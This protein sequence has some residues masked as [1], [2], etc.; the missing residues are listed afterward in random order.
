MTDEKMR[1]ENQNKENSSEMNV[2]IERAYAR[3]HEV[4]W[5]D[6]LKLS[7]L[8]TVLLYALYVIEKYQ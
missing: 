6:F 5:T 3:R 2:D 4:P 7:F 1:H 8:F